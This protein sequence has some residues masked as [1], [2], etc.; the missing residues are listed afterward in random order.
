MIDA[1]KRQ[2]VF[3][4][5]QEGIGRNQIARQLRI[6]PNTVQVIIEQKGEI[7]VRTRQDKIQ[8]DPD[9]LKR[10]YQECDGYAQR[11][12]EKLVEDER[13]QIQYSTLTRLLRDMGLR[14]SQEPRCE[15]MP[16]EP[17]AEMQHDTTRY[18]VLLGGVRTMLV[19]SLLYLR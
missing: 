4:L 10:L 19:A 6:S 18:A 3:L 11:V 7:A 8:V 1:D 16:D 14:R 12:H 13:I 5:H 17:G 9:L 2:A 15:R